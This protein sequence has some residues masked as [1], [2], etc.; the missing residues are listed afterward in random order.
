MLKDFGLDIDMFEVWIFVISTRR[1]LHQSFAWH[2][3]EDCWGGH[4]QHAAIY[5]RLTKQS[6]TGKMLSASVVR[7]W[8]KRSKHEDE[9]GQRPPNAPIASSYMTTSYSFLTFAT[10]QHITYEQHTGLRHTTS[11]YME[12]PF[13][14]LCKYFKKILSAIFA[15][16]FLSGAYNSFQQIIFYTHQ[17]KE[18]NHL[19]PSSVYS[20]TKNHRISS[21]NTR[22]IRS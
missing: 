8:A 13:Y 3:F 10:W 5:T 18:R 4:E 16:I 19:P 21:S 17:N 6:L 9:T 14:I 20:Y 12:Q 22:Y 15:F 1:F 7:C 2:L 11:I